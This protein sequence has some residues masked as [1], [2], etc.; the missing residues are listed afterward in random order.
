M[1]IGKLLYDILLLIE[2]Y[3]IYIIYI[4]SRIAFSLKYLLCYFCK[5]QL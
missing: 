4:Q 2:L 3:P 5:N 1:A